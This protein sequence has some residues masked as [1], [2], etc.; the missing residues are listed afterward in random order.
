[1]PVQPNASL[2]T[3]LACLQAVASARRPLGVR[4]AARALGLTHT[5]A[6]RLLG[7]LAD[8][9]LVAQDA[10][11]KYRPGPGIHV[12]AA[13]SLVG[14]RLLPA[15]LP[16]LRELR[17]EGFTVA[18]G[19]LWREQV[20]YLVHARPGQAVDEAIGSHE[21]VDAER[22]SLGMVLLSLQTSKRSGELAEIRQRRHA[23]LRFPNGEVS[24]GVPLG[25]PVIAGIAVSAPRIG[26]EH[27]AAIAAELHQA[28]RRIATAMEDAQP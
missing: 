27:T 23:V 1:M 10:Q 18:L 21:L 5:R 16:V 11:R 2:I 24:I 3:G 7:T 9:G 14:S 6:N 13:Q 4:E 19:V 12:L 28:A 15:A 25:D 22:S 17:R 8:L 26:E 20:C